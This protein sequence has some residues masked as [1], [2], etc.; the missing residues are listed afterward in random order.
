MYIFYDPNTN[1]IEATYSGKPHS[2]VWAERGYILA[3]VPNEWQ[4]HIGKNVVMDSGKIT[5]I[6]GERRIFVDPPTP[7][8]EKTQ[9]L[10]GR[11][12]DV[13]TPKEKDDLLLLLLE[14][15]GIVDEEGKIK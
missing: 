3:E 11:G 12:L 13:L 8:E 2:K 15:T 1:I 7:A 6:A 5:G 9:N 10:K 14:R 4:P